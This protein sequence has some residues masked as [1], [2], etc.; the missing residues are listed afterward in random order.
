[1]MKNKSKVILGILA[2]LCLS[3]TAFAAPLDRYEIDD[4]KESVTIYGSVE[5]AEYLDPI[6]IEVLNAGVELSKDDVHTTE[7]VKEDFVHITQLL[8]DKNGGYKLEIDMSGYDANFYSVRVNGKLGENKFFFATSATKKTEL[9]KIRL[10]C[11]SAQQVAVTRLV[12]ALDSKNPD[13]TIINMFGVTEDLVDEV[14]A[15]NLATVFYTKVKADATI[16]D[17][18]AN[19]KKA[20]EE[21]THIVAMNEGKGD[22]GLYGNE[23]GV[24][25]EMQRIYKEEL[26]SD[27][28]ASFVAD[29]FKGKEL[30]TIDKAKEAYEAGVMTGY[31][32][33]LDSLA[34][35]ETIIESYGK[36]AGVDMSDYKDLKTANKQKLFESIIDKGNLNTLAEFA[37]AVNSKVDDLLDDQKDSSSGGGGGG[38]GGGNSGNLV[39]GGNG[40]YDPILPSD[41]A[42]GFRDLAGYE[43][44]T[45]AVT[46]LNEK[47]IVN[48]VGDN[49]F[50]PERNVTRE[51]MVTMLI[52]AYGLDEEAKASDG[53]TT[54]ADV[55]ASA[56]YAPYIKVAYEKGYVTGISDTEFGVGRHITR[57]DTATMVNRVALSMGNNFS[58]ESD[59]F[60]DDSNI[61]DYAK[62]HVYALK[63]A[64]VISGMGDGTFAPKNECNRAQAAKIIYTLINK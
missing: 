46:A 32:A 17:T 3:A 14:D 53:V 34:D 23:L 26:T 2:C 31:L 19:L 21:A 25:E 12:A 5:G 1:M 40:G 54:F 49:M 13:S 63:N 37:S 51:E 55:D 57:E 45:E 28:K 59:A 24:S 11:N 30:F 33:S 43:W 15:K 47:G 10:M 4:T 50:A 60:S 58:I 6:A 27:A 62:Q 41:A 20:I 22:A 42:A 52:R 35:V 16:L 38:F 44:A 8:A 56:W 9:G 18:P 29:N 64:G 7:S 39:S 48:G 61:S 36:A